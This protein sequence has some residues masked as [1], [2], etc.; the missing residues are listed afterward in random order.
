MQKP[1][2]EKRLAKATRIAQPETRKPPPAPTGKKKAARTTELD[3]FLWAEGEQESGGDYLAV[4]SNSGALGKW[5]VMPANLPEW[6]RESG[7]QPM[8]PEQYLHSQTAQN[9][10]AVTILGG[11]YHKYGPRGAASVWY[12]GQPDFTKTYGDP[13]VYQYVNDV[14]A[15]MAKAPRGGFDAG[16][17]GKPLPGKGIT[18]ISGS[19]PAPGK[20]NWATSIV[21]ATGHLAQLSTAAD[22][23]TRSLNRM[24]IRK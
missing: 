24:S 21:T 13:P 1:Q 3:A 4:N 12:S 19:V 10:L 6:L 17:A 8:S 2:I 14:I 22:N 20:D 11:D 5:Q 15:L 9:K 23:H 16:P 18:V 7:L